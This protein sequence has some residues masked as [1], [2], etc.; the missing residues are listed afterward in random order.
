MIGTEA[1]YREAAAYIAQHLDHTPDVCIVLGS[2][3]GDFADRV[4]QARSLSYAEIPG[5]AP[6]SVAGHKGRLVLGSIGDR[7]VA[8]LQGRFHYYEGHPIQQVVL[9]IR[10]MRALGV[11]TLL[12]TNAA[13]GIN[14]GFTPGD[15]MMIT[16]HINFSGVNCL[17]GPNEDDLGPR[18]PDMSH[19]YSPALQEKLRAAARQSGVPLQE[20]VYAYMTG[21]SF[22]TPAEIRALRAL[23]ADAVGMSTVHEA[24]A[25]VHCGMETAAVSCVTNMAAGI[26]NQAITH[27]EVFETSR[28]ARERFE[29]LV[30]GFLKSM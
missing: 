3:L 2:G 22:E 18:F 30:T 13:G 4:E 12:L 11:R 25:A 14:E 27:E 6:T 7:Q 1:T 24:V 8:V 20:G 23:G 5:F 28:K 9:P 10:A 26:L 19:A 21:P 15:L 16:D 29:A 17:R